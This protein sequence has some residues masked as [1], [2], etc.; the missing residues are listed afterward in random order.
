MPHNYG[1][2]FAEV[3]SRAGCSRKQLLGTLDASLLLLRTQLSEEIVM[4]KDLNTSWWSLRVAYGVLPIVT[5]LDK[6][7][8]LLT[9]W[10]QYLS[11]VA[12]RILPFSPSTFMHLIGIIEIVAGIVV[13]TRYTRYAAYVVS[14]WLLCIALNLLIMGRYL[15]VAARDVIMAVGAFVLAHLTEAREYASSAAKATDLRRPAQASA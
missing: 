13:L 10:K 2:N 14:V 5:G 1:L 9:D 7:L 15:D 11:P 3:V 6:F 8:N 4:D 12:Q